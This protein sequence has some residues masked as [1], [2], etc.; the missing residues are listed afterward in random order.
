MLLGVDFP[1]EFLAKIFRRRADA[2]EVI[3]ITRRNL[4]KYVAEPR[5]GN[6]PQAVRF[7]CEVKVAQ[8]KT[9]QFT[10]LGLARC[11]FFLN[12]R[13]GCADG[14]TDGFHS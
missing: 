9:H 3:Q 13:A 1:P 5:H 14:V 4:F 10:A 8:E 2:L 11:I 6:R 7:P 12:L